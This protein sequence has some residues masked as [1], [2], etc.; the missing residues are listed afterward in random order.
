M[1]TPSIETPRTL[2]TI[3][4]ACT[5]LGCGRTHLYRLLREGKLQAVKLGARTMVPREALDAFIA[6]LP[7]IHPRF[8]A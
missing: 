2:V 5:T 8:A 7:P 6:A 1:G 4:G 3:E